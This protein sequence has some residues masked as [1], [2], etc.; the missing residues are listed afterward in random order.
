MKRKIGKGKPK[1]IAMWLIFVLIL[2]AIHLF[3]NELYNIY[4]LKVGRLEEMGIYKIDQTNP[5]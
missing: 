4:K 3:N 5:W 1:P 2:L